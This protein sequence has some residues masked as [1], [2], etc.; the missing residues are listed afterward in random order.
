MP[1]LNGHRSTKS[2]FQESDHTLIQQIGAGDQ[3]AMGNFW[4]IAAQLMQWHMDP[5]VYT[6]RIHLSRN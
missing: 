2:R 6:L 3:N 5:R 4:N 1:P